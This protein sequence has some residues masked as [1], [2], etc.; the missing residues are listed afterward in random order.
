ML[1][2]VWIIGFLGV[3]LSS[4]TV[5]DSM[6]TWDRYDSSMTLERDVGAAI[7]A[8]TKGSNYKKGRL[9]EAQQDSILLMLYGPKFGVKDDTLWIETK[10]IKRIRLNSSMRRQLGKSLNNKGVQL[11]ILDNGKIKKITS[12]VK[13]I[14]KTHIGVTRGSFKGREIKQIP[15]IDIVELR[16][17]NGVSTAVATAFPIALIILMI[18]N[19]N[20]I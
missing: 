1:Q 14:T 12:K 16:K 4:C 3:F 13:G 9:L 7:S 10:N 2:K 11:Y 15:L 18:S 6:S 17:V 5:Y 8:R 20:P 19:V